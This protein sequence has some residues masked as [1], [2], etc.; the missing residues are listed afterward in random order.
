M[1]KI[2]GSRNKK[3]DKACNVLAPT[4]RKK[5]KN[6]DWDLTRPAD[7]GPIDPELI[8]SYGRHVAGRICLG[9]EQS[10]LKS[11]LRYIEL[12]DVATDPHGR[13]S[14]SDRAACY[15]QYLLGS[16]LFT[17]KSGNVVP[18][19]LW[20]LVKNVRSCRGFAWGAVVL[21]YLYGNLG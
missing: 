5:A 15:I 13:L 1:N 21:A 9:Q 11:R 3:S 14:S 4:Q 8:P 10:M 18:T 20:S 12:F 17:D 6:S 2:A 7:G 19:K 16:S